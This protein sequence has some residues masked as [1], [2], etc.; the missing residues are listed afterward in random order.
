MY[1]VQLGLRPKIIFVRGNR[2]MFWPI[3]TK[4]ELLKIDPTKLLQGDG[5]RTVDNFAK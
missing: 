2:S 3:L 5:N 1:F 4:M